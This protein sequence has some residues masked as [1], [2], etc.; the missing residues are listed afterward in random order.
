MT[1]IVILNYSNAQL[2]LGCV[3][4]VIEHNSY[5]VKF[6]VVDNASPDGSMEDLQDGLSSRFESN[7]RVYTPG[8]APESLPSCSLIRSDVNGG[9]AQGNN[10]G[11]KFAENDSE[12][13]KILVLNNDIL[14]VEDILPEL[15][16]FLDSMPDAGIVSPLLLR[17]DGKS[18]DSNCARKDCSLKEIAC[19]YLLYCRDFFGILSK[20]A[21]KTKIL[22][23]NPELIDAPSVPIELPSGSCMLIEKGLFKEIGY[24]D[25]NTF[26]YYEESI[27]FRKLQAIHKVNY[28]LP[29]LTCIHLGAQTTS[30]VNRSYSYL[31]NS[32]KSAYY[33]VMH[34][35]DLNVLQRVGFAVL[36][37]LYNCLLFIK[38][39]LKFDQK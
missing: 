21:R 16:R 4:S 8:D 32:N 9:Y 22:V 12:I 15:V 5:P 19:Y 33:Y 36:Y 10:V 1:G 7:F 27:L 26:L 31:K 17:K 37:G 20:F 11:L 14:F 13:D 25:P 28:L 38:Q 35:R 23:N 6:I 30:N 29:R 3:D 34:Y 2:T 24:F 18:I 39:H